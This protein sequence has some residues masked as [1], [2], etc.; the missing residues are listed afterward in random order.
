MNEYQTQAL[1]QAYSFR[2]SRRFGRISFVCFHRLPDRVV[3]NYFEPFIFNCL[4]VSD[5]MADFR[6]FFK[7]V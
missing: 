5:R 2:N 7:G 6:F 4:H 3:R 1:Y